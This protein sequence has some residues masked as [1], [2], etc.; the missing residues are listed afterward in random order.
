[1]KWERKYVMKWGEVYH[2][3]EK[4]VMD[5]MEGEVCEEKVIMD[6]V[7]EKVKTRWREKQ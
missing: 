1:M 6:G 7:E 2:K 5:K 4:K 3:M